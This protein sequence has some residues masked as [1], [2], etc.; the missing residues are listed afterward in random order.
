MQIQKRCKVIIL[1]SEEMVKVRQIAKSKETG[2][3]YISHHDLKEPSDLYTVQHLYILSDDE[4]TNNDWYLAYDNTLCLRRSSL[5][6]EGDKKI[7]ASTDPKLGLPR[8]SNQFVHK[9]CQLGLIEEV[10]VHYEEREVEC[11]IEGCEVLHL[12]HMPVVSEEGIVSLRRARKFWTLDEVRKLT[13]SAYIE[14]IK[15]GRSMEELPTPR[16]RYNTWKAE[17]RVL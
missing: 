16:V 15:A 13:E 11:G 1:P 9:Y 5:S 10:I 7:I 12:E 3:L 14:G 17:N 8:P 2:E 6:L 4:I